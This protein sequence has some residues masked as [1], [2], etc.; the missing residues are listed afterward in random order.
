MIRINEKMWG[1]VNEK[2]EIL[3][4]PEDTAIAETRE[5]LERL[6]KVWGFI[7]SKGFIPKR[8]RIVLSD[9]V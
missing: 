4:F 5:A 6:R 9:E 2:G 1:L 8:I 7:D 3:E